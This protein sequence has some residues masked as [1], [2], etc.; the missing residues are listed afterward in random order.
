[1]K[2]SSDAFVNLPINEDSLTPLMRAVCYKDKQK[3]KEMVK[4]LI[5][6][7]ADVHAR[8]STGKTALYHAIN[9][10]N[11]DA[12][13]M[14]IRAGADPNYKYIKNKSLL[15]LAHEKGIKLEVD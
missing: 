9:S 12:I 11:F 14:L 10:K 15:D 3:S 5:E 2:Y 4:I 6:L 13:K 8:S 1:V 7:K